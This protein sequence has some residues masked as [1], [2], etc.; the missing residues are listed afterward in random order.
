[1]MI[2][3]LPVRP[4]SSPV[5]EPG[6]TVM[7]RVGCVVDHGAGVLQGEGS[8]A[9]AEFAGDDLDGDVAAGVAF[10]SVPS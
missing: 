9:S 8:G 5:P 6:T 7:T 2:F 1:M 10:G 4:V 3:M